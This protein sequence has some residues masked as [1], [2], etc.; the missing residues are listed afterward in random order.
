MPWQLRHEGSPQAINDLSLQQIADGLRDGQWEPTDEVIGPGDSNWQ[1]IE[2][3]PSLA[4]IAEDIETPPLVRHEEGT[5]LD[6]NAL[7]DVC[8]VL[9][10]FFILTTTYATTVRKVVPLPTVK[11]EGKKARVIDV[12]DV[13]E[14]MIRLQANVDGAGKPVLRLENQPIQ[15]LAPD[16]QTIDPDKLRD[17]LRPYVRGEDRKTEIILDAHDITWGTV[18]GIQDGA[19]AAGI[20]AIHHLL[21]K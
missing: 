5:H 8:L 17:A 3:H 16:G 19:K 6:F 21:K 1:A 13:K 4:E 15:V 9:L 2:S 12:K 14:R 7:I 11:A 18:I 20:H 10:I